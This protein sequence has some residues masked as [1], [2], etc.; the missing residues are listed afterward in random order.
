MSIETWKAEFYPVPADDESLDTDVKRVEHSLRKWEGL[1]PENMA[2]HG[3]SLDAF[4]GPVVVTSNNDGKRLRIDSST[5]ALCEEH[6]DAPT[7]PTCPLAIY[8]GDMC[9]GADMP[10]RDFVSD[11]NPHTMIDAL[12]GT[13]AMLEE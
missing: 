10:F 13:L 5:C 1:T 4:G 7:C 6:L 9:D 12:K 3:A 2:K 11:H 8:L